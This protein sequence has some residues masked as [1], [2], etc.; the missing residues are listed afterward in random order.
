M[1]RNFRCKRII[2]QST[3][4]RARRWVQSLCDRRVC[5]NFPL[6]D[7]L[8]EGVNTGLEHGN[9][10]CF[11]HFRSILDGWNGES[12]SLETRGEMRIYNCP[13]A[14]SRD[15]SCPSTEASKVAFKVTFHMEGTI[16]PCTALSLNWV[17]CTSLR[18]KYTGRNRHA[19]SAKFVYNKILSQSESQS[20]SESELISRIHISNLS[21]IAAYLFFIDKL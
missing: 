19:I 3:T 9:C 20:F 10:F 21:R 8:E 14:R 2:P 5:R 6:G 17:G 7:L 15:Y 18:E 11:R 13:N 16:G 1:T 4:C 12:M